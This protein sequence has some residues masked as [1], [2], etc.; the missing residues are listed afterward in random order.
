MLHFRGNVDLVP[1]YQ[2]VKRL[3]PFRMEIASA[4][5]FCPICGLRRN[6]FEPTRPFRC[7]GCGHTS[8]FGPV[9]AVG[10]IVA[11]DEGQ[12]LV[13]RRAREPGLGKLGLPGGFVDPQESSEEALH[14]E[15][16]EEVGL[17]VERVEYL[18]TAPNRYVYRGIEYPVLDI[19]YAARVAIAEQVMLADGEVSEWMWTDVD[20]QLIEQFAFPSNQAALEY[21]RK[22]RTG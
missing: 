17:R 18:M 11:N 19:F 16:A 2:S 10:A 22:W 6:R 13:I 9:T 15:I 20:D 8:F 12:I 4:Y 14:R 5:H 1:V 3:D 21:Y 7:E